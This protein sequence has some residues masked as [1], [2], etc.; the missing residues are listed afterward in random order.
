MVESVQYVIL[1]SGSFSYALMLV[2][3]LMHTTA[4]CSS[5]RGIVR[6]LMGGTRDFAMTRFTSTSS[7]LLVRMYSAN[8][9]NVVR[10]R[11]PFVEDLLWQSNPWRQIFCRMIFAVR[12]TGAKNSSGSKRLATL[13]RMSLYEKASLIGRILNTIM[14]LS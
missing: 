4:P 7:P 3:S 11:P 5:S 12:I 8:G 13:L 14:S 6:N 2:V 9:A 1:E 10:L